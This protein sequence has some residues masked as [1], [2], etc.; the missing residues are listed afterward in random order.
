MASRNLR[1]VLLGLVL[2]GCIVPATPPG[3]PAP[4]LADASGP[5]LALADCGCWEPAAAVDSAGRIFVVLSDAPR[6]AVSTDGGETYVE[7][8]TP[9]IPASEPEGQ[10]MVDGYI[11]VSPTDVLHYV[12]FLT[13]PLPTLAAPTGLH[14]ARSVDA[15][16]TWDA[17]FVL[18]LA[19]DPGRNVA[20]PWKSWVGF[21]PEGDVYVVYNQRGGIVMVGKSE[22]GGLSYGAFQRA[23]E[24]DVSISNFPASPVVDPGGRVAIAYFGDQTPAM[25]A[26]PFFFQGH[27]LKLAISD[28]AGATYR[29]VVARAAMAP[30]FVGTAFPS[31]AIDAAGRW[32]IAYWDY[33][34]QMVLVSSEDRGETWSEPVVW[35]EG[36]A[37]LAAPWL[38][39][40]GGDLVM[41]WQESTPRILWASG[42][43]G[44]A[45]APTARGVAADVFQ[46]DFAHFTTL[47]DGRIV[48][49]Y[50]GDGGL[51][52]AILRAG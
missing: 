32:H 49:P 8:A 37:P 21:G 47:T 45:P 18:S 52:V 22:D 30:E 26:N 3:S 14:V 46:G 41:L 9:P 16:E 20:S 25:G 4:G 17:N 13:P 23:N 12:A 35:S 11:A 42:P 19:N 15:G 7:R 44:P 31:L 34:E 39:S 6:L 2:S 51:R 33:A 27:A 10:V 36:G 50:P 40:R 24:G 48:V 29:T 5:V 43:A 28:D 1:F 38:A